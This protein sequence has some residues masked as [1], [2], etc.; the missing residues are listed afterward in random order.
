MQPSMIS[1]FLSLA[2]LGRIFADQ[3]VIYHERIRPGLDVGSP[4]FT[5]YDVTGF[6]H[7]AIRTNRRPTV[8]VNME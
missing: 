7:I 4:S 8:R 6:L 5:P 2:H 1:T 3:N